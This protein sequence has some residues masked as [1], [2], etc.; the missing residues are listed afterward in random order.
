MLSRLLTFC[1]NIFEKNNYK[2]KLSNIDLLKG[3]SDV[4]WLGRMEKISDN[5]LLLIDGGHNIDGVRSICEFVKLFN[6]ILKEQ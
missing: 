1:R 2:V 6:I 5:P 4:S 3:L